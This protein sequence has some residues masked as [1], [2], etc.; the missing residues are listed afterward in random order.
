MKIKHIGIGVLFLITLFGYA[1][2][3]IEQI[4]AVIVSPYNKNAYFFVGK[5]KVYQY[6]PKTKDRKIRKLGTDA[7]KGMPCLL[8][9]SP[10]P[11]DRQ[12]SRMPSSA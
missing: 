6:N 2:N 10:S 5:N 1:Q 8:Y 11:R 9:T 3:D 4:K 7:F 12:K